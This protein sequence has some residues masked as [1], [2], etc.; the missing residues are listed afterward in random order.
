MWEPAPA[1]HEDGGER[2][3]GTGAPADQRR[4]RMEREV[5]EKEEK[6]AGLCAVHC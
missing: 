6:G 5:E 4:K 2:R 1:R 3:L